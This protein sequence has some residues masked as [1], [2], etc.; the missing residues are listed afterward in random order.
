MIEQIVSTSEEKQDAELR[1]RPRVD[2]TLSRGG[3]GRSEADQDRDDQ[4]SNARS[5]YLRDQEP[6]GMLGHPQAH[7]QA[8]DQIQDQQEQVRQP[9]VRN[10]KNMNNP[11]G[12][13]FHAAARMFEPRRAAAQHMFYGESV[14]SAYISILA[15]QLEPICLE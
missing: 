3:A 9:P 14:R 4:I 6:P 7:G 11:G 13:L 10:R 1:T 8:D 12:S 5:G 15:S 2:V